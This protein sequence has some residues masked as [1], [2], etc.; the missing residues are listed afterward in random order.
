MKKLNITDTNPYGSRE[1]QLHS[2]YVVPSGKDDPA[3]HEEFADLLRKPSKKD[4]GDY[5]EVLYR[6][7]AQEHH[8]LLE[9]IIGERNLNQMDDDEFYWHIDALLYSNQE[10]ADPSITNSMLEPV[11]RNEQL[12]ED[13]KRALWRAKVSLDRHIKIYKEDFPD[14]M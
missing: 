9:L 2:L 6:L 11:M 4:I 3:Y 14:G 8:W 13:I 1:H 12:D 10:L 5:S 7:I